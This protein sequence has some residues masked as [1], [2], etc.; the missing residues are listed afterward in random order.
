VT[1][2]DELRG[3]RRAAGLTQRELASRA[4]M[5]VRAVRDIEVGR[6]LRPQAQSVHRLVAGLR[7]NS[8]ERD[9]LLATLTRLPEPP[10]PRLLVSILGPLAVHHGDT[11]VQLRAAKV[12]DLL[13]L[14]AIQ[15]N[16]LVL[17][18]E[19][20]D[21][22]WDNRV[23]KNFIALVH[24]HIARL[25]A[26]LGPDGR[27]PSPTRAVV[28][29]RGGFRLEL[30]DDQIDLMRFEAMARRAGSLRAHDPQSA[31]EWYAQAL[32][33][34]R[35]AVLA[36]LDSRLRHHPAAITIADRRVAVAL[37][38]ADLAI[39][40]G[41]FHAALPVLRAL[42]AVHPLHEGL[43]AR[44]MLALAGTGQQA[45]AL[46]VFTDLR[47]RLA[48]D[49]GISP[50]PDIT[51][52]YLRVLHQELPPAEGWAA[53]VRAMPVPAQL[54]PDVAGFVGRRSGLQRLTALLA[55]LDNDRGPVTVVIAGVAGVGKT[56]L[57]VHWARRVAPRFDDGQLYL[58]LRGYEPT[59]AALDPAGALHHLLDCLGVPAERVPPSLEARLGLYR[60]LLANRR[61]LVVLDNARD[62]EQVRP[63]LPGAPG[64]LTLVTSRN[65]L[66]GLVA[67]D[68]GHSLSVEP[69]SPTEA[70]ALL[71]ARL[72]HRRLQAE[73]AAVDE[74]IS[75]CAGLPLAL[76]I[77]AGR[78]AI[79]P[80][81]P[82]SALV[83][84]L[85]SA[86]GQLD[87][88]DRGEP[89]SDV[90]TVFSWSYRTLS[91]AAARLFRWLGRQGERDMV[92]SAVAVLA[93]LPEA[94][95]RRL[96]AELT[97]ANMITEH[98]P[99][100]YALHPLLRAYASELAHTHD[101]GTGPK[102]ARARSANLRA[103]SR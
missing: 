78:G 42:S 57:A 56:A 103:V 46:D 98:S 24:G 74:I 30:D 15:P 53:S 60:S 26:L 32:A 4:A 10:R 22:L 2:G 29:S 48:D 54:P 3:H 61:V 58:D 9:R 28:A 49:L 17:I 14:L 77:L 85:R 75:R 92:D 33:C 6:V 39:N 37:A 35:G 89:S 69:L 70:R 66:S 1:F 95:A 47:R 93:G 27:L 99:G 81:F 38:F 94:K 67:V 64:S 36:D 45:A 16:R 76:A 100:R 83:D 90:R 63:L 34:W 86:P 41:T 55:R 7:L 19:I 88:F 52:A 23:P 102:A 65:Q 71:A 79:H 101:S 18:D 51:Q 40:R 43:H 50:G 5:S 20:V 91:P 96:L 82:L 13:G 72:G 11:A 8:R 31:V 59:G 73:P 62:A 80:R 44:L 97:A 25:R 68:G 84:E 21:T 12:R 87:G